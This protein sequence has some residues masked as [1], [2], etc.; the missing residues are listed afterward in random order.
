MRWRRGGGGG[1]RRR[2]VGNRI[3]S[4]PCPVFRPHRP[5]TPDPRGRKLAITKAALLLCGDAAGG[6]RAGVERYDGGQCLLNGRGSAAAG[7]LASPTCKGKAVDCR[8]LLLVSLQPRDAYGAGPNCVRV[9][10]GGRG[11]HRPPCAG[12][13]RI[14][15]GRV[16]AQVAMSPTPPR[17]GLTRVVLQAKHRG[18]DLTGGRALCAHW[19][20][21][22]GR[23]RGGVR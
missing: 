21:R 15:V 19:G 4:R 9:W 16:G 14:G 23:G 10:D 8:R 11:W 17:D 2:G 12:W 1:T 22:V 6:G 13:W 3:S 20:P 5:A 7:P 18:D